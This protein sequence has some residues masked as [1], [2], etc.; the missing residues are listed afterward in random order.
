MNLPD[1]FLLYEYNDWATRRIL[2]ASA[3]VSP[4]QFMVPASHSFGSLRGTLVHTLDAEYSWRMLLQHNTLET[5]R[6]MKDEDFPTLE[7]LE[8]R[9][10]REHELMRAYLASLQEEGVSGIVR[11]TTPEGEKRER[12]RWHCLLHVV[13]HGTHHRS[14]AAAILTDFGHSPGDLDFTVFLNERRFSPSI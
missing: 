12:V 1:I 8:Q 3:Q 13:N 6:E 5:F 4:E 14:E 11:Y 10:M 9:W 7:A 2:T